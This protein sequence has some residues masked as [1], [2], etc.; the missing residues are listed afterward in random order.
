MS[1]IRTTWFK[2]ANGEEEGFPVTQCP[3]CLAT[4]RHHLTVDRPFGCSFCRHE[5]PADT[6]YFTTTHFPVPIGSPHLFLEKDADVEPNEY[7]IPTDVHAN[8]KL[9]REHLEQEHGIV[10]DKKLK[11]LQ[12]IHSGEHSK[13]VNEDGHNRQQEMETVGHTHGKVP[14]CGGSAA[15]TP[16]YDE[17]EELSNY[18][19]MT[20]SE[21]RRHLTEYHSILIH[22][23][24]DPN[25]EEY[26]EQHLNQHMPVP[27]IE[28]GYEYTRDQ[29]N[30]SHSHSSPLIGEGSDLVQD[31]QKM[32]EEIQNRPSR[33]ER[34]QSAIENYLNA[35]GPRI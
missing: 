19:D 13:F 2:E 29:M 28:Q 35:I 6:P 5:I 10:S 25:S 27:G 7:W 30:R 33:I 8:K 34:R 12:E 17:P 1:S 26:R 14:F 18:K 4:T 20:E 23:H 31:V 22:P 16:N 11:K 15:F 32:I 9:L 21:Q 24:E 3:N